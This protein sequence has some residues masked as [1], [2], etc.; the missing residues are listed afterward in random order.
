MVKDGTVKVPPRLKRLIG[1]SG[2][3]LALDFLTRRGLNL[4]QRNY[5][6]RLG[7]IDL[8]TLDQDTLV[9]VE[10]RF[11]RDLSHGTAVETVTPA[12]QKKIARCARHYLMHNPR[13][14]HLPCRFD[15][16]GLSFTTDSRGADIQWIKHAFDDCS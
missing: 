7:E 11:R 8:V 15:V 6:C 2:E 16:V 14:N 9:F 1:N 4:V 5:Q 13:F 10:V 12:K 3:D